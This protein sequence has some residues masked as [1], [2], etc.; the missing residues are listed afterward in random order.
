MQTSTFGGRAG[1]RS[2]LKQIDVLL[3]LVE[4]GPGRTQPE[5]ARAI[6][7]PKGYQQQVNQ[8]LARLV[9]SGDVECRG[10]G[11]FADPHKYHP[12]PPQ[13]TL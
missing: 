12:V 7:G 10:M 4:N 9:R 13:P 8:Y 1:R 2:E 6:H 3:Y 11:G 5:L